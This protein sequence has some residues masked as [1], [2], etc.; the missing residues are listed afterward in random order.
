MKNL[1]RRDRLLAKIPRSY[2]RQGGQGRVDA[3]SGSGRKNPRNGHV[4]QACRLCCSTCL[5]RRKNRPFGCASRSNYPS[6]AWLPEFDSSRPLSGFLMESTPSNS[7]A[8]WPFGHAA[9]TTPSTWC[10]Q[11]SRRVWSRLDSPSWE[12]A[13]C[14]CRAA[15][16]AGSAQPAVPDGAGRP[17]W[18]GSAE[19]ERC[20]H[21]PGAGGFRYAGAG[22]EAARHHGR[23]TPAATT[24]S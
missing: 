16:T 19:I 2:S 5:P 9:T 6:C 17:G 23:Q 24:T 1:T 7:A 20:L 13:E 3:S 18:R 10:C 12:T 4:A 21:H 14:A 22:L 8:C 11:T 15:K